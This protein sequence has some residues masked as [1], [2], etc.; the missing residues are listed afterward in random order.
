MHIIYT[1]FA[2]RYCGH[3]LSHDIYTIYVYKRGL[4]NYVK[5]V[6]LFTMALKILYSCYLLPH[7]IKCV[8]VIIIVNIGNS[9]MRALAVLNIIFNHKE[10][11]IHINEYSSLSHAINTIRHGY[12][13]CN[14]IEF[15]RLRVRVQQ[16]I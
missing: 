5:K 9:K 6:F 8:K 2:F 16:K 12:L 7:E 4:F 11:I 3:F 1:A 13:W 10:R 14:G 15:E